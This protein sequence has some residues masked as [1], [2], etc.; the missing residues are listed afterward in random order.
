MRARNI[1]PSI[2]KNE[3]L[4]ELPFEAR[5]LFSWLPMMADW[6]GRME[7]R[8]KR[9]KAELFPYD[10][11]DVDQLLTELH[12]KSFITRYEIENRGK[13]IWIIN[14]SKHQHPHKQERLKPS[15][16]P[17]F[18]PESKINIDNGTN[19][20]VKPFDNGKSRADSLNLIPDCGVPH[21]DSSDVLT[22][23]VDTSFENGKLVEVESPDFETI[24]GLIDYFSL[25]IKPTA[26][27]SPSRS[28]VGDVL[29][30]ITEFEIR[31]AILVQDNIYTTEDTPQRFKKGYKSFFE[32]GHINLLLSGQLKPEARK[33]AQAELSPS[34]QHLEKLKR[35]LAEKQRENKHE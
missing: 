33:S 20:D 22:P 10:N 11:V 24:D 28:V 3:D 8:P 29:N 14:F 26:M 7:D 4:A 9:I 21:T 34:Q 1:K 25:K 12:R 18:S 5:L 16:I 32:L 31:N 13:F 19:S 2:T 27:N 17:P 6:Q 23:I 35:D 30:K 15:E